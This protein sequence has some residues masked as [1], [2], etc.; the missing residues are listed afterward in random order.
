MKDDDYKVGDCFEFKERIKDFGMI[1][2]EDKVYSDGKQF[3]LFPVK[4]DTIKKGLDKFRFGKVY[5][6]S[7]PDYTKSS[8]K[9]EGFMV[10][11]FLYQKNFQIINKYFT[12]VGNVSIK[13]ITKTLQAEQWQTV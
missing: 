1:F 7:F 10:Y 9:T 11:Y 6:T 12:Y 2:L 5:L 13:E 4:L 3:S 8:G